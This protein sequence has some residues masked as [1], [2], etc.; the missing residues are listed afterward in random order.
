MTK[1]LEQVRLQTIKKQL[2]EYA[3]HYYVLDQPIATDQEYDRLYQELLAIESKYPEWITSDSPTQRVGG[4]LLDGFQKVTHAQAMYSLNNAFNEQDIEAFIERVKKSIPEEISFL[5]E[6]KIDG[7]AIA[8]TYQNGQL[9]RG[10]T[11]GDGTVGEDITHNLRTIP[12]IPLQLRK[13][14]NVEVRGEAYMPKSVFV[15]LN[16]KREENG[17]IPL[18]N[19]RNAAAGA[20]RQIKPQMARERQL[21]VFLYGAVLNDTFNP[22]TQE[23]LFEQLQAIG[24]RTNDFR[25]LCHSTQEV[26]K[27]I[28]EVAQKRHDLPYDIDGVVIKV[29]NIKQQQQLGYTVKAPRWAIAYKFPAEMAT[30]VVRDVEWTVGRT[31]VVTPTAVMDPVALA[32]TMV[33]RATLHNVDFIQALD[34]RIGDT[35][36]L[37]K[38]GDIIPEVL[39]VLVDQRTEQ[40]HS[41]M[42]PAQCPECGADLLRMDSEVALRCQ[43]PSCPAQQLAQLSHFVSRDAMNIVGL[44]K[45]I[46]EQLLQ[47]NLIQNAAD[48]YDLTVDDFLTL[49]KVKEKSAKKMV[50]AIEESK[51]RSLERLLFALGIRHVGAKAAQLVAQRFVT[52]RAIQEATFQ[53]L[54]EIDGLGVM[55]SQSLVNFFSLDE[56]ARLIQRFY[57]VGVQMSYQGVTIENRAQLSNEWVNKTVVITGS[58]EAFDRKTLKTQLESLGANVTGSVSKKTDYVIAGEAAGSKLSKAQEFGIRVIDERELMRLL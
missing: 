32:G 29:N 58:F 47:K 12:S 37:H 15:E 1:E 43:N 6:C 22:S 56:T 40:S 27:F 31:G 3:Y 19:P 33:Q 7:L 35:V 2:N 10:A 20:L 51:Q 4:Q 36:H 42:I 24:L 17:E 18:A 9:I 45:K 25:R 30:T 46:I 38:A 26:L 57:N 8:L 49:D 48:L 54:S 55:I 28:H 11:R 34:V 13:A 52:M 14:V 21:N 44:G 50:D 53:E 23:Q 39:E 16:A 41:L 5:C